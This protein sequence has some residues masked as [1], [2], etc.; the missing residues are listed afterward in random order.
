MRSRRPRKV[1]TPGQLVE[2]QR[3]VGRAWES[4]TYVEAHEDW[5]G[6][7]SIE[8]PAD[9]VPKIFEHDGKRY[10]LRGLSVPTQRVRSRG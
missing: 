8:L 7:H 4:A 6:W 3:E 9:A 2:I 10:E 1:F 5:R